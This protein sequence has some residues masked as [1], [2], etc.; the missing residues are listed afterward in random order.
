MQLKKDNSE[1]L[2][3]G[4]REECTIRLMVVYFSQ[5]HVQYK[6]SPVDVSLFPV[7]TF[8]AFILLLCLVSFSYSLCFDITHDGVTNI[9]VDVT[10]P[11]TF[12]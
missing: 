4:E 6:C 12:H 1:T 9:M 5:W 10:I 7:Y 2:G 3:P 8:P 11:V